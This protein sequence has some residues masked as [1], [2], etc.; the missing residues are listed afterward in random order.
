VDPLSPEV[1]K[2]LHENIDSVEQL[3]ILRVLAEDPGREWAMADLS[4]V[5][6]STAD[7]LAADV[8]VLQSRGLLNLQLVEGRKSV[9][10]GP[11]SAELEEQTQR[12]MEAYRQRPVTMIRLVYARATAQLQAFADAFKLRKEE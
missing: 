6:Q 1:R 2:F 3:E 4:K 7:Q 11:R 8:V 10:N 5:V 9:R 12:L